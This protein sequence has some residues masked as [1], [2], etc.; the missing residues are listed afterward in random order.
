MVI[1]LSALSSQD[2][3]HYAQ[4]RESIAGGL[5]RGLD[6]GLRGAFGYMDAWL[7]LGLRLILASRFVG[8]ELLLD[9]VWMQESGLLA[10]GLVDLFLICIRFN[11]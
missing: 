2:I 11:S 4:T 10:V 7:L 1:P 9:F 8:D 5:G 6:F 3:G